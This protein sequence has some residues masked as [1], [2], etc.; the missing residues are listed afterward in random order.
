MGRY[1]SVVSEKE[2]SN[3]STQTL[4]CVKQV[5]QE[6][7]EEWDESMPLPGDIIEGIADTDMEELYVPAKAKSELS[8]QLGKIISQHGEVIWVKVRRGANTIKLRARIVQF[9]CTMLQRKY[10]IKAAADDRHVVVLGDLTLEQCTQL[11]GRF[12]FSSG[13]EYN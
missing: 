8:S 4:V 7:L 9:K 11:Q 3:T 2:M 12:T 10:T 1:C 6:W 5:K 13:L